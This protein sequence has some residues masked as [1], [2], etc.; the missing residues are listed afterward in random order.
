MAKIL[1]GESTTFAE[2]LVMPRLTRKNCTPDKVSLRIPITRYS[3]KKGRESA[4]IFLNIP[5][6]SASMQAVTGP[7]MGIALA[8]GGGIGFIYCSQP[9]EKQARMVE[10]V[11]HAKA[12]FVKAETLNLEQTVGDAL[13]K[14]ELTGHSTYP[15]VDSDGRMIGT[16]NTNYIGDGN[17]RTDQK[18]SEVMWEF[19]PKELDAI[20]NELNTRNAGPQTIIK[21]VDEYIP[22][23]YSGITLK[24]ANKK[25][26][27]LRGKK[28]LAIIN[29]DGTLDSLVFRQDIEQHMSHPYE[30]VD[31]QKRYIAAAGINTHDY[32]QRVPALAEAGV[33]IMCID[34]SDG[35]TEWQRD[36]IRFCKRDYPEIPIVGGNI[37]TA[38]AFHY[39]VKA[40]ADAI[41]IGMGGGAICITRE[42]KGVGRGQAEAVREV[43]EARDRHYKETGIYIPTISDG[44]LVNPKDFI[45]AYGLGT[46]AVMCGRI[47]V[48]AEESNA[49][50]HPDNKRLKAYWGE[51]SN[52]ARNWQRY[53]E[54]TEGMKFE[55]GV[56]G[57]VPYAGRLKENI[58]DDITAR[59]ISTMINAGARDIHE[60]H[61]K[62][63]LQHI[64][65]L[66]LKEGKAH[67]ILLQT[68]EL[69]TYTAKNWGLGPGR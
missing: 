22:F 8:Q 67:D 4:Q 68:D 31:E 35:F 27:S 37:V 18:L 50:F 69:G 62:A 24:E 39:L 51:G 12:G 10:Q 57:Y 7:K 64:S 53:T 59:I 28:F 20:V 17:R 65:P 43:C 11:K 47:F 56:D 54:G 14:E 32:R 49:P 19:K 3:R 26:K 63:I 16:V 52:R 41:K 33:N 45:V 40:G 15:I 29:K 1:K 21:A 2:Y 42:Q 36:C 46:D 44:G 61:K 9:I 55:E 66:A 34:S 58:L 30:L 60:F 6:T 5:Y 48:G 38:E 23:A 25:L 13:V